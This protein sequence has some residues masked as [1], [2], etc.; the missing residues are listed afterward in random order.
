VI[1]D[2]GPYG[3]IMMRHVDRPPE[4]GERGVD[5]T[6]DGGVLGEETGVFAKIA[7]QEHQPNAEKRRRYDPTPHERV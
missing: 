4:V 5:G 6:I 2:D 3:L 1:P 7:G